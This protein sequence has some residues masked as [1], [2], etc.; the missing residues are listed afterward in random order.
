MDK[1]HDIKSRIW[2]TG[3]FILLALYLLVPA[4]YYWENHLLLQVIAILLMLT[5][6][7]LAAIA[8]IQMRRFF[9]VFPE[10][11]S[12]GYLLQ[13][14]AFAIC[15]HPMYA[16]LLLL[17]LGY[18]MFWAHTG[19]LVIVLGCCIWMYY[20]A[21]FEEE[22]LSRVYSDYLDYQLQV[23]MFPWLRRG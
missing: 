12:S 1:Q 15:R 19:K 20:K 21:R 7:F 5:G 8:F 3:Q 18:A 13:R 23:P 10:P 14:G 4:Y 11:K 16:G 17:L 9:S 6:F 2:V 22:Q